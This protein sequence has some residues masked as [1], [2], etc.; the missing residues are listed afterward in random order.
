MM[1]RTAGTE[2]LAALKSIGLK[3]AID[4]FGTGYSNPPTSSV[5]T[6]IA[7]DRSVLVRN[8]DSKPDAAVIRTPS[9]AWDA[10]SVQ[11]PRRRR[12]DGS[13]TGCITCG[14]LR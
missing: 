9:S 12:R 6:S 13:R 5:S 2:T 14:R 1:A 8:I 7:Q 4:D 3:L 10:D 11:H